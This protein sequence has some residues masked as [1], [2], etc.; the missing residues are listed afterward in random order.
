MAEDAE[1][2]GRSNAAEFRDIACADR[3]GKAGYV[4]PQ[5]GGGEAP[6]DVTLGSA[7]VATLCDHR[8]FRYA[9]QVYDPRGHD[10]GEGC[11]AV[12][13]AWPEDRG[14]MVRGQKL[15][16]GRSE[17]NVQISEDEAEWIH[18]VF[19]DEAKVPGGVGRHVLQ[20]AN[21]GCDV[22]RV[23][24]TP[25][26]ARAVQECGRYDTRGAAGEPRRSN[27]IG[28][29]QNEDH[30]RKSVGEVGQDSTG[31]VLLAWHMAVSRC[32]LEYTWRDLLCLLCDHDTCTGH[33]FMLIRL[34]HYAMVDCVHTVDPFHY[35]YDTQ[36]AMDSVR[37]CFCRLLDYHKLRKFLCD[38]GDLYVLQALVAARTHM[39]DMICMSLGYFA[40]DMHGV[41]RALAAKETIRL[42]QYMGF[43]PSARMIVY[44]DTHGHTTVAVLAERAEVHA[45]Q[46][47]LLVQ[48]DAQQHIEHRHHSILLMLELFKDPAAFRYPDWKVLSAFAIVIARCCDHSGDL[49]LHRRI[50]NLVAVPDSWDTRGSHVIVA[51]ADIICTC[52]Y[53]KDTIQLCA[54]LLLGLDESGEVTCKP[55]ANSSRMSLGH[56]P[57]LMPTRVRDVGCRWWHRTLA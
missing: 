30:L 42:L 7:P 26:T 53:M 45:V 56:E 52:P 29:E 43:M 54:N 5:Y 47:G 55:K 51:L 24:Y 21:V 10:H 3:V 22:A 38:A 34:L 9:D 2:R 36:W 49:L 4:A 31:R 8:G 46:F 48:L 41:S 20:T 44:L 32:D 11:S 15:E 25:D 50:C 27:L 33:R 1:C 6:H 35:A 17:R 57:H 18:K 40:N 14:E 19:G 39:V 16:S 12:G 37:S 28:F 13:R 23:G